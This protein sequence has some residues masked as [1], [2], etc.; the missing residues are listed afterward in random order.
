MPD[1]HAIGMLSSLLDDALGPPPGCPSLS[2][3]HSPYSLGSL[4]KVLGVWSTLL[5]QPQITLIPT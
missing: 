3:Y 2:Q 4:R 5:P 1:W